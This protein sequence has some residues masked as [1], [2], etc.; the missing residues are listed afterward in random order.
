MILQTYIPNTPLET[1]VPIANNAAS[2]NIFQLHGQLSHYFP[3][4]EGFGVEEYALP[5]G[6][7]IVELHMLHR[8]GARY[9]TSSEGVVGLG[10][11][12]VNFT[13]KGQ[14]FEGSLGFLNDWRYRLG[15]EILVP[16]GKQELFD[17]GSLHQV[18]ID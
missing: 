4:T 9:P 14:H 10:E 11:K 16:V 6:A 18:C 3:N 13:T 8:H 7:E 5:H 1:Q 15:A 17:S 2:E 12:I